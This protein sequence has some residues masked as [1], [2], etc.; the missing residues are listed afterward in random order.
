MSL[1]QRRKMVDRK[2]PSRDKTDRQH[3]TKDPSNHES[4][5]AS[6]TAGHQELYKI[7]P[8]WKSNFAHI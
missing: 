5:S 3:S 2:H 4:P 7:H 6:Q 1:A 8:A